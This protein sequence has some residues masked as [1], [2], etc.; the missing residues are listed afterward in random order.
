MAIAVNFL[1]AKHGNEV[2]DVC[3]SIQERN[4]YLQ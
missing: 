2:V 3:W 4:F 1:F